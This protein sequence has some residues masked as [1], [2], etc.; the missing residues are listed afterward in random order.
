MSF[1]FCFFRHFDRLII[2]VLVNRWF[3][4]VILVYDMTN[5]S[6]FDNLIDWARLVKQ[7]AASRPVHLAI[8]ANKSLFHIIYYTFLYN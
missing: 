2:F 8:V 5:Q 6:S 1:L 7:H 4:A 3:Q